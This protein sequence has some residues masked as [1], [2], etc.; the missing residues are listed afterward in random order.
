M[1]IEYS[2]DTPTQVIAEI[3]VLRERGLT[4]EA[5][6]E[7]IRNSGYPISCMTVSNILRKFNE[8]TLGSKRENCG[9]KQFFDEEET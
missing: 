4:Q 7:S 5:I 2:Y 1:E 9:R 8:R 3:C 6:A